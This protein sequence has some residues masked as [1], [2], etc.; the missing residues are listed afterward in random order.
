[1]GVGGLALQEAVE[2]VGLRVRDVE[3][4]E[5]RR[6]LRQA[7]RELAGQVGVDDRERHE[8]RD[9][10]AEREHERGR[11]RAGPVDVGEREA[12]RRPARARQAAGER[13]DAERDEA[14]E[15]EGA[16]RGADEHQRDAPVIGREQAHSPTRAATETASAAR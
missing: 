1:M 3:E 7:L 9:A 13:H 15:H 4:E 16:G 2:G 8:E 14:Q 12:R 10:E 6:L 11:E 5:A